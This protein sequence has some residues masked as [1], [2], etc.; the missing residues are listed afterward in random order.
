MHL[1]G[2]E[3]VLIVEDEAAI[4][5]LAKIVLEEH[6]YKV[7]GA[8]SPSE[9][10]AA[11]ENDIEKIDLLITDV[12]MPGMNGKELKERIEVKYPAIKVLFMSGYT[13]DIVAHRGVLEEGVEFL[14]KPFTPVMFLRKV[15]EV[16][17]G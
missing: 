14:Q 9:A 3:T 15:R 11:C 12:V 7:L 4:L 16:L 10:L 17:N 1:T 8:Q 6:G 13:A 5:S 2:T